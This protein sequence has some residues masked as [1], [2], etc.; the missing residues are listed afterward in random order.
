MLSMFAS[1]ASIFCKAGICE[2]AAYPHMLVWFDSV[3]TVATVVTCVT[4]PLIPTVPS[5]TVTRRLFAGHR[6]S[7]R[8]P[9]LE[10]YS[11]MF[12]TVFFN[13]PIGVN[14]IY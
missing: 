14:A 3:V 5:V 12:S 10:T 6:T 8:N 4:L 7:A 1:V 11:R 2:F 13:A 9:S